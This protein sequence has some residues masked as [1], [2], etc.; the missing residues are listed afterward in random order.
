MRKTIALM[1][2]LMTGVLQSCGTTYDVVYNQ[3]V[4]TLSTQIN[5]Q[6]GI[7]GFGYYD[8][9]G[10]F[11]GPNNVYSYGPRVV[12]IP[13]RNEKNNNRN[14]NGSTTSVRSNGRRGSAAVNRQKGPQTG[15]SS[16]GVSRTNGKRAQ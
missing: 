12:I 10:R 14:T 9:Y 1:A 3:P 6:Y 8:N 15:R 2:L 7:Y 5:Y 13:R 4:S 11:Y 16:N